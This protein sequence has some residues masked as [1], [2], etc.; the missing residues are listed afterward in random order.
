MSN[1]FADGLTG[2]YSNHVA[3]GWAP[4][5]IIGRVP[6]PIA[7]SKPINLIAQS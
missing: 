2:L 5:A 3:Q 1:C 4:D 6:F 7:C